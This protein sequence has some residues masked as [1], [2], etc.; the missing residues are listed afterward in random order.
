MELF[1]E[2]IV[3]RKKTGLDIAII[4]GEITACVV[5]ALAAFAFIPSI[6]M[7]LS[8]ALGYGTWYLVTMR[9][10]EFEYALTN[11]ELD[12]DRII[13]RRRRKRIFSANGKEF[14]MVAPVKSVYYSN[15]FKTM[16]K[17]IDATAGKEAEGVW[18]IVTHIGGDRGVVL[19]QPTSN[20]IEALWHM[21]PRK[22]MRS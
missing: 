17:V 5:L 12:I 11:G 7:F 1:M 2:K 18:F 20:M 22:V 13:A 14:E 19:F 16:K 21:N 15:E 9:S 8:V 10:M 4:T 6:G 3:K